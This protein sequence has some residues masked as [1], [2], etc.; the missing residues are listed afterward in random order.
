MSRMYAWGIGA[1][2]FAAFIVP[3]ALIGEERMGHDQF[4]ALAYTCIVVAG[5]VVA[6]L[7]D[8]DRRRRN[9]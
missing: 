7:E 2:V 8:A 6:L 3:M 5:G 9:R 1:I 4:T